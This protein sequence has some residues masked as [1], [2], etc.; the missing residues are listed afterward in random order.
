MIRQ[1]K[2]YSVL[3]FLT[4]SVYTLY[5]LCFSIC[6]QPYTVSCHGCPQA[7]EGAFALPWK[8]EKVEFTWHATATP[9]CKLITKQNALWY[10]Y[11][12]NAHKYVIFTEKLKIFCGGHSPLPIPHV[13]R[14]YSRPSSVVEFNPKKTG[15][16]TNNSITNRDWQLY[17]SVSPK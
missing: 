12:R 3:V 4:S 9:L 13:T 7:R 16:K 10:L 14:C 15:N 6:L 8:T 17:Y 5:C 1:K 2:K 11:V